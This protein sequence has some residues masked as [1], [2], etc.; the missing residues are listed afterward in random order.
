MTMALYVVQGP[1]AGGK[2]TWVRTHARPGDVVIDLYA[3][4]AALTVGEPGHRH[5]H[6]VLRCARRAWRVAVDE[7]L[8][9]VDTVDVYVVHSMP[10]EQVMARYAE[11]GA[12]VVTCDP[13]RDT[14]LARIATER[15][16]EA[17]AVAGRW[18]ARPVDQASG[19]TVGEHG[20]ERK[21]SSR[22]W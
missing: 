16:A 8:A 9:Y 2:T 12:R 7:A 22:A 4:A 18:Y 21:I 6:A 1:P 15:P 17:K 10:S 19:V 5:E 14:V 11:H 13:G 20:P 3:I